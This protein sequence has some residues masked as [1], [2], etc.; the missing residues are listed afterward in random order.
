MERPKPKKGQGSQVERSVSTAQTGTNRVN[1]WTNGLLGVTNNTKVSEI[2][3]LKTSALTTDSKVQILSIISLFIQFS[4]ILNCTEAVTIIGTCLII[5]A[6]ADHYNNK[7]LECSALIVLVNITAN[8][9]TINVTKAINFNTSLTLPFPLIFTIAK[10]WLT[11]EWIGAIGRII[12]IIL[13]N[14]LIISQTL[15]IIKSKTI[16][17]T[18]AVTKYRAAQI[19]GV[20]VDHPNI[21]IHITSRPALGVG[22]AAIMDLAPAIH[23]ECLL[24][25]VITKITAFEDL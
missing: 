11:I 6:A 21:I 1:A 24:G 16:S 8:F 25:A 4:T 12:T 9:L 17:N 7:S 19:S 20:V 5:A 22:M 2:V 15:R 18:E 3:L 13:V 23:D 10:L 14:L